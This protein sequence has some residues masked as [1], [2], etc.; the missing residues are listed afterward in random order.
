MSDRFR[1]ANLPLFALAWARREER[2]FAHPMTCIDF[3]GICRK[4]VKERLLLSLVYGHLV[5]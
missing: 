1:M 2:G 5:A 4:S 3:I